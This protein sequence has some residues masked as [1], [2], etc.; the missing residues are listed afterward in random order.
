MMRCGDSHPQVVSVHIDHNQLLCDWLR[1]Q[2][3]GDR[4]IRIDEPET[5]RGPKI[6]PLR[7]KRKQDA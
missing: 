3:V 6:L 5:I 7:V 4:V 2:R 1:R